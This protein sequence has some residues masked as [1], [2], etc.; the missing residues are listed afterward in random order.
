LGHSSEWTCFQKQSC[1]FYLSWN[2]SI[3]QAHLNQEHQNPICEFCKQTFNS[4]VRLDEHKQKEC[5]QITIPCAL[6][7]YGCLGSVSW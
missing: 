2:L 5:T 1:H 7:D 3:F 6:K 4:T